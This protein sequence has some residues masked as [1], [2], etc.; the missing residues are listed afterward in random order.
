V[1]ENP[2]E[3]GV[4]LNIPGVGMIGHSLG[5]PGRD[6]KT[7]RISFNQIPGSKI[8]PGV[9]AV[10]DTKI[11]RIIDLGDAAALGCAV[12]LTTGLTSSRGEGDVRTA[13]MQ[14]GFT[15]GPDLVGVGVDRAAG[16]MTFAFDQVVA[17]ST[18]LKGHGVPAPAAGATTVGGLLSPA[19]DLLTDAKPSLTVTVQVRP[20]QL[21][22]AAGG[23]LVSGGGFAGLPV[24]FGSNLGSANIVPFLGLPVTQFPS[25]GAPAVG[26][27]TGAPALNQAAGGVPV[28][29]R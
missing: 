10:Q 29:P 23:L 17:P 3:K 5:R 14:K 13:P 8:A 7:I 20:D 12:S 2:L 11:V 28:R 24:A 22:A 6:P 4:R 19:G 25:P 26:D 18:W 15:E 21:D 16:T 27:F 9:E 1:P